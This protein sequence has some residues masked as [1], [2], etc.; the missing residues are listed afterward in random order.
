MNPKYPY[1]GASVD[2]VVSCPQRGWNGDMTLPWAAAKIP[3]STVKVLVERSHKTNHNCYV[4]G[5]MA[6]TELKWQILCFGQSEG[7]VCRAFNFVPKLGSLCKQSYT[8]STQAKLH[9]FYLHGFLAELFTGR[10][11]RK[12]ALYP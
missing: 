10:V 5:Q 2:G 11:M 7:S 9:A 3:V 12:K 8:P 1:L 6:T 4:M